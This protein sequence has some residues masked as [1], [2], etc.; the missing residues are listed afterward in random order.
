M[1]GQSELKPAV[2]LSAQMIADDRA[3]VEMAR[4]LDMAGFG[5]IAISGF[6]GALSYAVSLAHLTTSIPFFSCIQPIY[7]AHPIEIAR[8]ARHVRS[9]AGE[10]FSLGLGVS[11]VPV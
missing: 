6:G 2:N 5:G 3:A 11:H 7:L 8:Q 4:D 10:R 1:T 9:F